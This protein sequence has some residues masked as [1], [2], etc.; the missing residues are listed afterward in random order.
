MD[1]LK[2][3]GN[4][5]QSVWAR[6]T[7]AQKWL[8]AS[9]TI[10]SIAVLVVVGYWA[11]TPELVTLANHLSP[12][13]SAEF[14]SALESSN[15]DYKL[16]FAG[17]SILVSQQEL[18]QARLA[19]R[20]LI[21]IDEAIEEESASSLWTDPS[22][23]QERLARQQ[24]A[25]L[26]RTLQQMKSIRQATIHITQPQIS[27]FVRDQTPAKASVTLE[28]QP[29]V[30]FTPSD[31]GAVASLIAHSVENLSPDQVTILSTD[32][33]L[34]SATSGIE[35][36][37]TGQLEY[38][39]QLESR[40][41]AKAENLLIPLLGVGNATVRVTA[42]VDFT[43]VERTQRIIDQDSKA[44]VREEIRTE[45]YSNPNPVPLGPPGT[46]SNLTVNNSPA[47]PHQRGN[48]ESEDLTTEYINGETTDLIREFPGR[49]K[50]LTIAAVVQLPE[51]EEIAESSAGLSPTETQSGAVTLNDLE[52]IIQNAVGFDAS[53]G[54]EIRVVAAKL[55]GV[56]A[57]LPPPVFGQNF[58]DYAPLLRAVSLGVA[59]IVALILGLITLRKMK[60][61]TISTP[62]GNSLSPEVVERLHALT[63][64]MQSHPEV[65]T[66]ILA[67]WLDTEK[68][69]DVSKKRAA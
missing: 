49:V 23:H 24:E 63:E 19:V 66:T 54:D 36:H 14:V 43:E 11:T 64:Q 56:P 68:N 60:P 51:S 2:E 3:L 52:A 15:I 39:S 6:W 35:S 62:Q 38:R 67:S 57:I 69:P 48:H 31:A 16:N 25:R 55:S 34:L 32:G 26:A 20:D 4:Q 61:M 41:S 47:T 46:S 17:S 29:G 33:Q 40:L 21:D 1:S 5:L 45:S 58:N 10:V 59:A 37:V 9:A 53:R 30:P 7:L 65:V 13:Q 18:G 44:K 27:P 28:L 42:D 12:A 8:M 50:R 22:L